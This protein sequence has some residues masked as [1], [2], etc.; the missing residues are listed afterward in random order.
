MCA[1]VHG[2]K[3]M[4]NMCVTKG[5]ETQRVHSQTKQPLEIFQYMYKH[6][7]GIAYY[8]MNNEDK[9]TLKE[10]LHFQLVGLQIE[11]NAE[12]DS[13]VKFSIGPGETKFIEL[14]SVGPQWKIGLKMGYSTS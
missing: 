9:I 4:M 12:G 6:Q 3:Q 11:G 10:E 1:V 5:K 7:A 8:Y 2:P 13:S 14:K